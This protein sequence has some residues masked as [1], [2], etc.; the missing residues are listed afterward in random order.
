M[1]K[2]VVVFDASYTRP[3]VCA[4][5]HYV[6]TT[7]PHMFN[8]FYITHLSKTLNQSEGGLPLY[9]QR[10]HWRSRHERAVGPP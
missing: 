10:K 7:F 5:G 2:Y 9:P 1:S 6:N 8:L 4:S 3:L